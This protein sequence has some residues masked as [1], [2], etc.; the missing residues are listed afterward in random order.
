MVGNGGGGQ[1]N[2][3]A[4]STIVTKT[5]IVY[6]GDAPPCHGG[7]LY[8]RDQQSQLGHPR[9]VIAGAGAQDQELY[10]QQPR[11][12]FPVEVVQFDGGGE[13]FGADARSRCTRRAASSSI[14]PMEGRSQSRGRLLRNPTLVPARSVNVMSKRSTTLA[15][16]SSISTLLGGGGHPQC[17]YYDGATAMPRCRGRSKQSRTSGLNVVNLTSVVTIATEFIN[18]AISTSRDVGR[19]L[20]V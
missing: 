17:Q 2:F 3:N 20:L 14:P 11:R 9:L 8:W 15:K 5:K 10:R 1:A 19:G 16:A 12:G 18:H 7:R 6:G 4:G 13:A